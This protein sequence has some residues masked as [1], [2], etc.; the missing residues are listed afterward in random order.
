MAKSGLPTGEIS[1]YEALLF[2]A[3]LYCFYWIVG[4]QNSLLQLFPKLD[5]DQQKRAFFN[6]YL[7]FSVAGVLTAALLFLTKNIVVNNLTRFTDLPYLD[8]IALFL[9]FNCPTF[10]NHIYYLLLKK[11]YAIVVYGSVVFLLQLLAVVVPIYLGLTLREVLYGLIIWAILKYLW[12]VIILIKNAAWKLDV[13]FIKKYI[14]LALP[15]LTYAF[16][17]KGSEYI[18][19]LAVTTLF[20]D[21]N[22]FAVFRYGAREFPI[23]VLMVGALAT[24]MIPVVS[25]NMEIGLEELKKT[26][27]KLS[28][29][30]FP[31]SVLTM[32]LSPVLFPIVFNED[33]KES[34]YIFNIFT[35]LLTS[36]ILLPQVVAMGMQ[37]NYILT[38]SAIVEM[39][40]LV[41]LSWW[42]GT[43]FGLQGVAFAAVAAFMVDRIVLLYY[44]WKI[45][46]IPLT[47][48]VDVKSYLSY[49]ALL[50]VGFL[51]SMQL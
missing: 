31:L 51:I 20:D 33:F 49:N 41:A 43:S 13:V 50:L 38:F 35:L 48:Y 34:A 16:I 25:R 22:A 18:S 14:P 46:K 29:W 24:S 4:G 28:H 32:L 37:K 27:R 47:K 10:L 8:L 23:A 15:L 11:Y 39:V 45:L 26:T 42:W 19:G 30:L 5:P 36:R 1:I 17:G 21:E 40:V 6:V 9:L 12:G 3:S 44:N 7:I 2:V